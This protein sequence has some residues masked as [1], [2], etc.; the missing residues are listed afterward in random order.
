[1]AFSK[2]NETSMKTCV[3]YLYE[4][5]H[6]FWYRPMYTIIN[7]IISFYENYEFSKKIWD[8]TKIFSAFYKIL[9]DLDSSESHKIYTCTFTLNCRKIYKKHAKP[10]NNKLQELRLKGN[11]NNDDLINKEKFTTK[12]SLFFYSEVI[13]SMQI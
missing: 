8:S 12:K 3:V 5:L 10:L 11:P 6:A 2:L 1:M 13:W 4:N 9:N 7:L